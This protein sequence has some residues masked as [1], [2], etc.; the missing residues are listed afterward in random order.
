MD[1]K[2]YNGV[3]DVH[4]N[5]PLWYVLLNHGDPLNGSNAEYAK[6]YA[7]V[8]AAFSKYVSYLKKQRELLSEDRELYL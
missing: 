1:K 6:L 7:E 5:E 2:E 4:E 3:C 8:N